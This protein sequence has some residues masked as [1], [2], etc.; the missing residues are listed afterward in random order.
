MG[1]D[2]E[3]L[4]LLFF[5]LGGVVVIAVALAVSFYALKVSRKRL[6]ETEKEKS[7]IAIEEKQNMLKASIDGGEK[8][9]KKIAEELHDHINAQLTVVRMSL[10][11]NKDE[12]SAGA[13]EQIDGTIQE[14]RGLSRELMPPVLERFGLLDALDDLFDK[15]EGTGSLHVD[16]DAPDEW[17]NNQLDRDLALYRITQEFVQN[18]MKYGRASEIKVLVKRGDGNIHLVLKDDGVGFNQ[19][20]IKE[21][22]GTRNIR[23][24]VEYLRGESELYS[25]PGEG[26]ELKLV[27]PDVAEN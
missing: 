2:S 9:R 12:I 7:R 25:K 6:I 8:E 24:R 3:I 27:I 17:E 23:S 14:L 21:G 11:R 22:V 5:L 20:E 19:N 18:T 15:V 4:A 16:F 10:T 1:G 13:I 26:V